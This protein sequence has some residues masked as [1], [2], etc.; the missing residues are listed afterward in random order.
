MGRGRGSVGPAGTG[1]HQ[2]FVF[3][4]LAWL[5]RRARPDIDVH[6]LAETSGK[7]G[8]PHR[9]AILRLLGAQQRGW[10]VVDAEGPFARERTFLSTFLPG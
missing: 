10:V 9:P 2:F 5:A 6:L 7:I 8:E 3:P 4:A 1:S